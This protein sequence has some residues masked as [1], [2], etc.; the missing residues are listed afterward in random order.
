MTIYAGLGKLASESYLVSYDLAK[1]HL[2]VLASNARRDRRS[3][4]DDG[5]A[6]SIRG[7]VADPPR[8]RLIVVVQRY[9]PKQAVNGIWEYKPA[10]G[11]W[12]QLLPMTLRLPATGGDLGYCLSVS[13][14]RNEQIDVMI[15]SGYFQ[16]DL[17]TDKAMSLFQRATTND[18]VLP[19]DTPVIAG[20]TTGARN[21]ILAHWPPAIG[22]AAFD[23]PWV[24]AG[25]YGQHP[26]NRCNILTGQ[27]EYFGTL[28][29]EFAV[30]FQ[31]RFLTPIGDESR[32]LVGDY[33]GLWLL[34]IRNA[35]KQHE[36]K[37]EK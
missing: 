15:A 9:E 17:R 12:K 10:N 31:P 8:H 20:V 1:R 29:P 27:H 26:W 5:T 32:I 6:F 3:P 37:P 14:A 13:A 19:N 25:G 30:N 35:E 34:S 36:G 28:R 16:F 22:A 23:P 33:N 11:Q 24:W 4:L 2:D 21:A 18:P 7:L